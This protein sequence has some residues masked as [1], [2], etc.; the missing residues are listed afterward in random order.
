MAIPFLNHLDL[1][2]VSQLQ[3]ALLHKTTSGVATAVEAKIIYDTGTNTIKYYDGTQWIELGGDTDNY[4]DSL[5]FNTGDG[6]LTV[7]R[8]G[9]LSDLT[10][11][12]D[13][14]YQLAGN[15]DN[16]QQWQITDGSQTDDVTTD[17]VVK[18]AANS[19]PGTAG[20]ALTG[21][22]TA[23]N[24]YVITYTFPNDNDDN[25]VD[26]MSLSG[27]TLTLTRTGSLSDLTQDLSSIVPSDVVDGTGAAGQVAYWFDS[28]TITGENDFGW[29]AA[30]N[31]L[32]I[33]VGLS[34]TAN[35]DIDRNVADLATS[36][37]LTDTRASVKIVGSTQDSQLT[38]S[39][40]SGG[41]EQIQASNAAADT[42]KPL[43]LNPYGGDVYINV[44]DTG[45]GSTALLVL[46]TTTTQY[47]QINMTSNTVNNDGSIINAS[48]ELTLRIAN[49]ST[50]Q[51][52]LD[53]SGYVHF[54]TYGSGNV[55]GT[56]A[57]N[58]S[59]TS[60]GKIIETT[61]VQNTDVLQGIS[62]DSSNN[63]RFIT[64]VASATGDQQ[65]FSHNTLKYNP[66]TETLSVT[67]LIVSGTS[68]TINTEEINLADN[69][70]R[71]NS[72]YSG[73]TPTENAGIEVE[74]GT[75][76][77]VQL[78][79]D[80]A[81]DDWEFTAY[82]HAGTPALTTYKIPRTYSTTVGGST[83]IAVNHYLGTRNVMVQ[84]FDTSSYETVYADVV[85]T[86]LNTVTLTFAAAP[87]AGDIT[88]LISTVN[89]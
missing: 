10:V 3:N 22:G 88:V 15:Y 34:P 61:P 49:S 76:P 14:R 79:W 59:V 58:L 26:G 63:D 75:Q 8:T 24:P 57:K 84:L 86:N 17:Q 12:L 29:D 32:G 21:A 35:L 27:N 54:K 33:G 80:E 89:A 42:A 6:V 45:A 66:S 56:E 71:L 82:N 31:R 70:I 55:E 36:L 67:N 7:G 85:R 9:S 78:N 30:N 13:G 87:A 1:T 39:H 44:N 83:S 28:D 69:I 2:D 38:F 19:S 41:T 18:F 60:A 64:T 50:E 11:D 81:D 77:N 37:A 23:V 65:G 53:D 20:V 43:S 4:V 48:H 74:R 73:S 5:A 68:T 25:Y 72:N 62:S 40:G 47:S 46:G 52:V 51:I 16:Y